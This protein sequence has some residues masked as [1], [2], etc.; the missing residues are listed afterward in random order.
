MA[1]QHP[2][3]IKLS[4]GI[5]SVWVNHIW[6]MSIK[7]FINYTNG[8]FNKSSIGDRSLMIK[9]SRE[10]IFCATKIDQTVADRIEPN[11]TIFVNNL[12]CFF[13][14][15]FLKKLQT[16]NLSIDILQK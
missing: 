8:V 12:V 5:D 4:N 6:H 9:S 1:E 10:H 13:F 2:S 14:V 11:E 7:K 16:K 15:F 3:I